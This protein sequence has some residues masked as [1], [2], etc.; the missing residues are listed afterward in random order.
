MA[1]TSVSRIEVGGDGPEGGNS[2]YLVADRAV[3]D[4]GPPT[5]RAWQELH[6]ASNA[7]A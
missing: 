6:T 4:P 3:I 7:P 1:A 2:A 5:E